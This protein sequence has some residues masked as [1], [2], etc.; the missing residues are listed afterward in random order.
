MVLSYG[1]YHCGKDDVHY[2]GNTQHLYNLYAFVVMLCL[3]FLLGPG[4]FMS[5]INGYVVL[6][7]KNAGS[8][9]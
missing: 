9:P 6:A 8:R 5:N 4:G 1:K 2:K 7:L 3:W